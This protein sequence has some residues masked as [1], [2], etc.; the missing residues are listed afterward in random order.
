MDSSETPVQRPVTLDISAEVDGEA[1]IDALASS[2]P[3]S[4]SPDIVFQEESI[5]LG[6]EPFVTPPG[7]DTPSASP[8]DRLNDQMM[9]SVMIS[10]SPNN[11]EEDDMTPIDSLLDQFE[12]K[13]QE[14][15]EGN[16]A[17]EEDRKEGKED[18]SIGQDTT[19]IKGEAEEE[20]GGVCSVT[21]ENHESENVEAKSEEQDIVTVSI[22]AVIPGDT[23]SPSGPPSIDP[24]TEATK[25]PTLPS[26]EALP[27]CTIFSQEPKP[28]ALVPDGF[29][30]TL[31]KSPS[32]SSGGGVVVE[33]EAP[34]KLT[35]LVCQPSPS[36]SKFFSDNGQV[37]PASDFFDSFTTS[38][39][40]ISVSNPNSESP[41]SASAGST[42]L[43][44]PRQRSSAGASIA[45]PGPPDS[46][47]SA[48][49]FY[50]TP[51][52]KSVV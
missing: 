34:N 8:L 37:N 49:S 4:S 13:G 19:E 25:G 44:E 45:T 5:D 16:D 51:D 6:G 18:V 28:K 52:R 46:D 26:A 36:L 11:S 27:V 20:E 24:A 22:S 15:G 1:T 47:T 30:P 42:P 7:E 29:Q 17:G 40:F 23:P 9:E 12:D 2:K 10:D 43:P 39:S 38:S 33:S 31:I 35:P 48:A 41:A 32:F 21:G 3:P 14:E 50:F